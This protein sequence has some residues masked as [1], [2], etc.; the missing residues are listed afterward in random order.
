MSSYLAQA[1]SWFD[2]LN[3]IFV[4]DYLC[5]LCCK[6]K[7]KCDLNIS[8]Q[9]VVRNSAS[10]GY[11]LVS[12]LSRQ[13]RQ[14]AIKSIEISRLE[15]FQAAYPAF[16]SGAPPSAQRRGACLFWHGIILPAALA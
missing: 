12:G 7:T 9:F 16:C 10:S 4:F 3:M 13:L 11:S 15:A 5:W 14:E 6:L 2:G 1:I 8:K